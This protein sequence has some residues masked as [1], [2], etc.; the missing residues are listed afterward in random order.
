V[1]PTDEEVMTAYW[2]GAGLTDAGTGDHILRGLRA[3]LA[4]WGQP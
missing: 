4:R 1:A 2:Q 3:V